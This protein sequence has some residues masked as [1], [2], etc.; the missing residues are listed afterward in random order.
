MVAYMPTFVPASFVILLCSIYCPSTTLCCKRTT[1]YEATVS[2][3]NYCI[4]YCLCI[5]IRFISELL[6]NILPCIRC[7]PVNRKR[8]RR[9]AVLLIESL[10][11]KG[12]LITIGQRV[13]ACLCAE[14][15]TDIR[16]PIL[17][18]KYKRHNFHN[19]SIE[20]A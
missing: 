1:L 10:E 9:L 6:Y 16:K 13:K 3:P 18:S 20:T 5:R 11:I 14:T 4:I 17:L 8:I 7:Y 2:F 12:Y 19:A 15:V